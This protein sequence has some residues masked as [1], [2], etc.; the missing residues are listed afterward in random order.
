LIIKSHVRGGYRAAAAYLKAQGQNEKVRLVEISDPDASN[1]DEAF[2]KMWEVASVTKVKKA[3]H[4]ISINPYADERLTKEQVLKII[5]RC[6]EKYGYKEGDHQRVIVEHIKN[7]RQHFHVVWNR[8]SL[9]QGKAIWPGEHWNKS[10]QAA[11]EMERKLGLKRPVPKWMVRARKNHQLNLTRRSQSFKPPFL[12]KKPNHFVRWCQEEK[13]RRTFFPALTAMLRRYY[14]ELANSR[15]R[16]KKHYPL[17]PLTARAIRIA[18]AFKN[19][20]G[21]L[22]AMDGIYVEFEND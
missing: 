7:G 8:V 6:E 20:R 18:E 22:L 19:R 14:E 9:E 4:H 1:L 2:Q 3:L 21:D 16:G 17:D 5:K 10:K 11:R 13:P 15:P 12:G